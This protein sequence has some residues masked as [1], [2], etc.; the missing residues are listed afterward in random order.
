LAVPLITFLLY[1]TNA[2]RSAAQQTRLV[3]PL[4]VSSIISFSSEAII[5]FNFKSTLH[6]ALREEDRL[7]LS[8]WDKS[9]EWIRNPMN[10]SGS[11]PW[12]SLAPAI[13]FMVMTGMLNRAL[14]SKPQRDTWFEVNNQILNALFTLMCLY[15]HPRRFYH[16]ALLCR[17]RAGDMHQ[18]RQVYCKDGTCKPNERKHMTYGCHPA[19]CSTSTA[20]L[21]TRCVASTLATGDHS[22][23]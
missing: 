3:F 7:G 9:K 2:W 23:R 6:C 14:P 17:W 12:A 11:S 13:L 4:L 1:Q 20:L 8:L 10:M 16:L 19:S 21:S 5:I 15:Q 22:V 18:L